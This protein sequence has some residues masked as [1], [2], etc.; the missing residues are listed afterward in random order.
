MHQIW[1]EEN[2]IRFYLEL[3]N[4][5]TLLETFNVCLQKTLLKQRFNVF[6]S[7]NII[8]TFKIDVLDYVII[9]SSKIHV[10]P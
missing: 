8:F 9:K 7:V 6:Y 5:K 2:Y 3:D 4:L 10:F 1:L